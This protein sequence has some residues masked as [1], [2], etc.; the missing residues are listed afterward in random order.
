MNKQIY[1]LDYI[2]S[3]RVTRFIYIFD[4]T[5]DFCFILLL[6][7]FIFTLI[8]FL[9]GYVNQYQN[10][11]IY[12]ATLVGEFL[13]FV[14]LQVPKILMQINLIKLFYDAE[15]V[16]KNTLWFSSLLIRERSNYSVKVTCS[17]K[18]F[19]FIQFRTSPIHIWLSQIYIAVLIRNWNVSDV[20]KNKF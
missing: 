5:E 14:K 12:E 20:C 16:Y 19:S 8:Q 15:C 18:Q 2:Y 4:H 7:E 10:Q 3:N 1:N 17:E 11:I 9:L 13:Y 6:T